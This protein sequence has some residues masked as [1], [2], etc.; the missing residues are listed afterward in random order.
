MTRQG[1]YKTSVWGDEQGGMILGF[2]FLLP[3]LVALSFGAIEISTLMFDF[4]RA[5]EATRRAAR[6]AAI[7]E[8]VPDLSTFARSDVVTCQG[9]SGGGVSCSGA[10]VANSATFTELMTQ[11]QEMQ[12]AIQP[13][14]VILIYQDSGLG[15][16]TTPGGILPLVTVRISSLERPLMVV[17]GFMGLPESF[18][19][20][21]FVTTQMAN[22]IGSTT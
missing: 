2:G 14:N 13:E 6:V 18:T 1:K 15:D 5:N 22:G 16:P 20:P 4:H 8:P 12:P 3:F 19:Y 7:E 11:V 10:D 9:V 17:G 21:D